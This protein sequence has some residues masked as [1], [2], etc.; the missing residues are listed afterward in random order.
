MNSLSKLSTG[1]NIIILLVLFLFANFVL[2]PAVYPKFETLDT[3]F[4]YS[5]REAYSL[6][7]SYGEQ[8]RKAYLVV[9]LTL[10]IIYP[11]VSTFL[12][13][14]AILYTFQRAFPAKEGLHKLAL[15]PFGILVA[16]YLENACVA[17][18]LLSYPRELPILAQVSNIFT[19]IKFALT[20]FELLV[21]IGLIGWFIQSI[22]SRR[23]N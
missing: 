12:F 6:L 19:V 4:S 2:I 9:E 1:R 13:S 22:H 7:S 11:L 14:L 17:T 16:D 21:F 18:M 5:P 8:G 23:R 15:I 20:P 3:K 10:D